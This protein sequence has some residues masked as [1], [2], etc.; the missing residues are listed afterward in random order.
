MFDD[1]TLPHSLV[2]SAVPEG[3]NGCDGGNMF[4]SFMYIIF[5]DGIDTA[6]SY[7]YQ[8]TVKNHTIS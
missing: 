4:N 6:K 7:R 3:N 5:N 1:V 8:A 2:T